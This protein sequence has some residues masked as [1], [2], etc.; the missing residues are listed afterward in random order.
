MQSSQ[1]FQTHA[2]III[3]FGQTISLRLGNGNVKNITK[4]EALLIKELEVQKISIHTTG[5]LIF[6]VIILLLVYADII[7]FKSFIKCHTVM[8]GFQ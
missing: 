3:L 1:C 6:V 5:H 4:E 2:I 8:Q 7:D